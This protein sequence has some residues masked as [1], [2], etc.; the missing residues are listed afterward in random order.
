METDLRSHL[1]SNRKEYDLPWYDILLPIISEM[2]PEI[3]TKEKYD[4]L[5]PVTNSQFNAVSNNEPKVKA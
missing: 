4:S 5:K 1:I 2:L 3:Q